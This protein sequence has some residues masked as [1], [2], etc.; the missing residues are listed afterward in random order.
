MWLLKGVE[1]S[2]KA[3]M[4]QTVHL[5]VVGQEEPQLVVY[6]QDPEKVGRTRHV[7]AQDLMPLNC[8][9]IRIFCHIH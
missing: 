2:K 4:P 5:Q 7:K 3:R 9:P 8:I 1:V 6:F